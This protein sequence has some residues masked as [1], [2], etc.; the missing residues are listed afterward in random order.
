[1]ERK[2]PATRARIIENIIYKGFAER[3]KK[4]LIAT[5]KG[6]SLVTIVEDTFKFTKTTDE[7]IDFVMYGILCQ[8]F[9]RSDLKKFVIIN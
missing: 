1:M 7:R 8:N 3:D 9:S 6:I 5:H 4:N 2:A